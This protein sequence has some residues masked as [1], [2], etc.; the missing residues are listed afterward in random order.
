MRR[1][2]QFLALGLVLLLVM[3]AS[4]LT[5]M[6]YAIHGREVN[7]PNLMGKTVTE[8]QEAANALGLTLIMENK[9]YS[10][11]IPAGRIV[12]QFPVPGSQVRKGWRVRGAES[13]GPQRS[14]IPNLVGQSSR[15][16]EI[17][18]SRRGLALSSIAL[19][20]L[21]DVPP[22]QIVAQNPPAHASGVTSPQISLLVAAPET[23]AVYVM[24]TFI[25]RHLAE[26]MPKLEDAGMKL[27]DLTEAAP[28]GTPQARTKSFADSTIIL[29]QSP[30]PGQKVTPGTTVSFVISR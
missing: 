4:A 27:G 5:A 7:V 16:A 30:A 10:D 12:S 28:A 23:E 17:N 9:F 19:A 8:A 2:V 3:M 20:R 25:G 24:P 13:M 15:A 21:Q 1:F 6:R 26:V 29:K 11:R 18:V 22:G 14:D